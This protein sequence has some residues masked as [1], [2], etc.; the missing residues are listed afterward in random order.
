MLG[1][2]CSE[3]IFIVILMDDSSVGGRLK[4]KTFVALRICGLICFCRKYRCYPQKLERF[5]IKLRKSISRQFKYTKK[6]EV[7]KLPIAHKRKKGF[8]SI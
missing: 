5:L 1:F 4:L 3:V 7:S 8:N 6:L 2:V